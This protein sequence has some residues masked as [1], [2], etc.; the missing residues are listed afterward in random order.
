MFTIKCSFGEIVDKQTILYIKKEKITEP[1]AY[2]NVCNEYEI[3]NDV[4]MKNK[5]EEIEKIYKE[6]LKVNKKLWKLE[7]D[8]RIKSNEKDFSEKYIGL[9]ESIHKTNDERCLLKRKINIL[10]K[11]DIKEEKF[12]TQK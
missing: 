7:D 3:L 11:S 5:T 1:S 9:S 2:K 6:L 10:C 12:Y 4:Y 8:I